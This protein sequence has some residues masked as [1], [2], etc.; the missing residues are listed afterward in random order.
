MDGGPGRQAKA[1]HRLTSVAVRYN[2]HGDC[3]QHPNLSHSLVLAVYMYSCGF[4]WTVFVSR[5][6]LGMT[7]LCRV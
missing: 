1:C 4:G 2:S 5:E 6:Q 3:C 7:V